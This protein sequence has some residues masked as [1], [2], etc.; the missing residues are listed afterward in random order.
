MKEIKAQLKFPL[1]DKR[2]VAALNFSRIG[3]VGS[4]D[5]AQLVAEDAA[6]ERLVLTDTKLFAEPDCCHLLHM[7]PPRLLEKQTLVARFHHDLDSKTLQIKPLSIIS[8]DEIVRLT[9]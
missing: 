6:G 1:A 5:S 9:Y 2:P 8:T 7:L 3:V 4:G